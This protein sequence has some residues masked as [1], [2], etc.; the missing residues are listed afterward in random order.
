MFDHW[1]RVFWALLH[2]RPVMYRMSIDRGTILKTPET[3]MLSN[4]FIGSPPGRDNVRVVDDENV[5]VA[6]LFGDGKDDT[7]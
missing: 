2:N 4:T 3:V 6:C 1:W 7:K 5:V